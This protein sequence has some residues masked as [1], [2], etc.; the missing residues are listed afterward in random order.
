MNPRIFKG[1]RKDNLYKNKDGIYTDVLVN[2][3]TIV[4]G[5][6]ENQIGTTI[7]N[8]EV[9]IIEHSNHFLISPFGDEYNRTYKIYDNIERN[10][11]QNIDE[12]S[13]INYELENINGFFCAN[14]F[15]FSNSGHDLSV[16]LDNVDYIKKNNIKDVIIFKG[17][18][19]TNNFKLYIHL[20]DEDVTFHEL[21]PETIYKFKK[22]IIKYQEF[23]NVLK[24]TYLINDLQ[25]VIKEKYSHLYTDYKDKKL[26]LI[27][28]NR[29]KN[30]LLENTR[31]NCED[32]LLRLEGL[33]YI[34]IIPEETDVF[35]LALMLMHAKK[36]IFSVG[37]VLY[38]N[39]IFFNTNAKLYHLD[40]HKLNQACINNLYETHDVTHIIYYK[41]TIQQIVNKL[42]E[43]DVKAAAMEVDK[44]DVEVEKA[45][46]KVDNVDV[47]VD[48]AA[49]EVAK[50]VVEVAKAA[51]EV[52]KADVEVAK[53]DVEV[54]KADVKV[55][56]A[57]VEVDKAAVEV[58]K[59][60]VEVAKADVELAKAAVE[61]DKV[62]V[63]VDKADVEVGNVDVEVDKADVEVDNV[64]VEENKA[65]VEVDNA[66]VE[67]NKADL[68]ED[69]AEAVVDADANLE[70]K[71]E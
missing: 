69:K 42:G 49:V 21:L 16:S 24:H 7:I 25:T 64:D 62:D 56:K 12:N 10:F 40:K 41:N 58:A 59:A 53:A 33:N 31:I 51:V 9:K 5:Q 60:V 55:D 48:K 47:E 28:S 61:V 3:G 65:D 43:S 66:D 32:L 14:P 70:V 8:D 54:E 30:V 22:I 57:A 68:E 67:V 44:A 37:S 1:K 39:K 50:A 38:T 71:E 4:K 20:L 63:K 45:D 19:D 26:I 6:F 11:N 13:N 36:I 17:T 15:V 2:T 27:K 23:Y 18:K 52:A 46:V 35:L 29:N 34:N